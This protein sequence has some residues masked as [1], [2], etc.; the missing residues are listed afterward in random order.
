MQ[1]LVHETKREFCSSYMQLLDVNEIGWIL[2]NEFDFDNFYQ[3][4]VKQ[5]DGYSEEGLNMFLVFF[6]Y[7]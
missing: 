2:N 4:L 1:Q 5:K 6:L 7:T 3:N